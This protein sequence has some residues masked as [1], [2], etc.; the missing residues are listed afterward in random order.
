MTTFM[1]SATAAVPRCGTCGQ[2][3]P[4][5]DPN[6]AVGSH[7]SVEECLRAMTQ[8]V[9]ATEEKLAALEAEVASATRVT[10]PLCHGEGWTPGDMLERQT[11]DLCHGR[12]TIK[13]ATEKAWREDPSQTFR[14]P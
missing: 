5:Y 8:R 4:R 7:G 6:G 1:Q 11:C 9:M 14:D 10:C 12:K 3:N 2:P 13:L